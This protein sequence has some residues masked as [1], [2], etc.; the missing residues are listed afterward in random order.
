M[1][2]IHST[3]DFVQTALAVASKPQRSE[4]PCEWSPGVIEDPVSGSITE[5]PEI[6][7]TGLR[8]LRKHMDLCAVSGEVRYPRRDDQFMLPFL[9][10]K[11]YKVAD[12]LTCI[13]KFSDFWCVAMKPWL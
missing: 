1:E 8:L 3:L 2:L 13:N 5:T 9:R 11:K 6:R 12:A 4:A 10:C 7:E